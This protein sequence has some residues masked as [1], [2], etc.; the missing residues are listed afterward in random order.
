[1]YSKL[2]I[3]ELYDIS[4]PEVKLNINDFL[5]CLNECFQIFQDQEEISLQVQI[6]IGEYEIINT[7]KCK[8]IALEFC[9]QKPI[10]LSKD[11]ESILEKK[12]KNANT[13]IFFEQYCIKLELPMLL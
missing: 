13:N 2:H 9:S 11:Q 3:K 10:F 4:I 6:K 8:I 5:L 12:A 7:K 1:L